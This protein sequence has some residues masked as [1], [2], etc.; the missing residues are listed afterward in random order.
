MDC[1]DINT[2]SRLGETES[3]GGTVSYEGHLPPQDLL[4]E[5]KGRRR[6]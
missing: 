2:S 4:G 5:Y 6:G 1:C 3:F